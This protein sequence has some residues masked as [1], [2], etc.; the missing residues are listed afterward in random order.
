MKKKV[1]K[2]GNSLA[3]TVPS[4]FV[5]AIGVRKG[6]E[7]EVRVNKEKFKVTYRFSGV[8]QMSIFEKR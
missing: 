6:D 1:I 5:K 3:V 4:S 8:C 7:V 2:T